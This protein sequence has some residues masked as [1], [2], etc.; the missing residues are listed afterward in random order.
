MEKNAKTENSSHSTLFFRLTLAFTLLSLAFSAV[1]VF[2]GLFTG[3]FASDTFAIAA[4]PSVITTLYSLTVLLLAFL[5]NKSTLEAEDRILLEQR[6][7]TGRTFDT[8]EDVLFTARRTYEQYRKYSEYVAA[9]LGAAFIA[10]A[11]FA[12]N[13]AWGDAG[14]VGTLPAKQAALVSL[15]MAVAAVLAGVFCIGQSRS[16]VF[17]WLR[18]V[19][20]WFVLN[21]LSL[22]LA[23]LAIVMKGNGLASWD[24]FASRFLFAVFVA[25]AVELL[26]NFVIEFYRPR[27]KSEEK[28]V[29]E[30]RIL[31]VITEPGGVLRNISDTLDYQ[32]GFQVS[33]T[34][35][36]R[37]LERSIAPLLLMWLGLL[38]LATAFDEVPSGDLGVM[39]VFGRRGTETLTPGFYLKWPWPI[40]RIRKFPVDR[41]QEIFI[42]SQLKTK[43]KEKN[44][45]VV[46]WTQPH[47]AKEV[48]FLVATK[49]QAAD[50]TETTPR[51]SLPAQKTPETNHDAESTAMTDEEPVSFITAL[52]P[53]QFRIRPRQLMRYAYGYKDPV[54]T[55]KLIS[56]R[57]ITN[58]FASTDMLSVMSDGR[59]E[60]V[61]HITRAIRKEADRMRLG[62]EIVAVLLLDAHP[63]I[64][65]ELPQ[66]F[67]D[68]VAARER[69]ESMILDAKKY[70]AA[71]LPAAEAEATSL[72]ADAEAYRDSRIKVSKAESERFLKRLTGYNA[73]PEMYL[74]NEKMRFL[75]K[76][77]AA[78]RK[79]IVPNSTKSDVFVINLEEKRRLDLLDIGDLKEPPP[80]TGEDSK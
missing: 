25:L 13:R 17:R 37:F 79:Y 62:V 7:K 8:E 44:P 39:E 34:W 1:C 66:A 74:L 35:I 30:S 50:R 56:E 51:S 57:I 3:W 5:K 15:V 41:V 52:L 19:G 46:L 58:Y 73:M 49:P 70:R 18:P 40:G 28:P 71:T 63:P 11:L 65:D 20:V 27:T 36:Y 10:V 23:S 42:G 43:G 16:L 61:K 76:D 26:V 64:Q 48:R 2:F 6:K 55:L 53:V 24:Y 60:A 80:K 38:W 14:G 32:F 22:T 31:S 47:Y 77:C 59:D 68:V 29:F 67:Q 72:V 75:I 9:A 45:S 78:L 4:I 69:K 12:I 54:N 21:S 33:G